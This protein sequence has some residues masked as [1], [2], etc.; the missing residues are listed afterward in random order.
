MSSG[1]LGVFVNILIVV[2]GL[3][4]ER[5]LRGGEGYGGHLRGRVDTLYDS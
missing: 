5:R 2:L 1:V 4:D 3:D